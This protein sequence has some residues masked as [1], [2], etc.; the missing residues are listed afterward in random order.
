MSLY[1]FEEPNKYGRIRRNAMF[2]QPVRERLAYKFNHG[3][4][5]IS[6]SISD[7]LDKNDIT[8]RSLAD[9]DSPGKVK[10]VSVKTTLLC[11]PSFFSH[12]S[13]KLS[14]QSWGIL[15]KN[16][17]RDGIFSNARIEKVNLMREHPPL[18]K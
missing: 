14:K 4:P 13:L 7:R 18:M 11:K 16:E 9:H 3:L 12:F 10:I 17:A 8:E 1:S 6:L 15:G 5:N 2:D